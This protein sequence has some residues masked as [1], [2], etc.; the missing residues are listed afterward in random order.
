MYET[1]KIIPFVKITTIK[2]KIK[3]AKNCKVII[4]TFEQCHLLINI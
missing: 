3:I 4:Q 2:L 1:K